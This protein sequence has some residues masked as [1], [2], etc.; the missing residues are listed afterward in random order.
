MIV[1]Y[2]NITLDFTALPGKSTE[3]MLRRGVTHF[4]GN[5]QAAKVTG[6]KQKLAEDKVF[7]SDDEIAAKKAEYVAVA[8][9]ALEE[10]TVGTAT[11][12]PAADPIEAEMERI[13][14]REI[15]G[16]LKTNNAKFTGKGDERK[17]TFAN[18]DSFTMDELVERR[19]SGV[20]KETGQPHAD[21]LRKLAEKAI[22]DAARQAEKAKAAGGLA[23]AS[24]IG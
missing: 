3:A 7:P 14:K 18:G 23:D 19:L 11:R 22:K 10:G 12:G 17:V 13:A 1:T 8:L 21:R 15:N 4:L 20:D 16:I 2:G 6:W 24:A 5:E 9:K